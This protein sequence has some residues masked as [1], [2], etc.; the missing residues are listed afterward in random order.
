MRA[1]RAS[2]SIRARSAGQASSSSST[3]R[4]GKRSA[5]AAASAGRSLEQPAEL[6]HRLAAVDR[7]RGAQHR[8]VQLVDLRELPLARRRVKVGVPA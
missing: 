1:L 3:I 5:T 8:V 2:S 6:E 4:W 7:P